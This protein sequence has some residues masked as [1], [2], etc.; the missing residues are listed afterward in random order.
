MSIVERLSSKASKHRPIH[1]EL[2]APA[3]PLA[4]PDLKTTA[5]E[6]GVRY[7]ESLSEFPTSAE[8]VGRIPIA[9]ARTAWPDGTG[10]TRRIICPSDQQCRLLATD[11]YH[12]PLSRPRC[13]ADICTS[14]AVQSAINLAYQERSGQ[15]RQ[16]IEHLDRASVLQELE[17]LTGREDLLDS[18]GRAPVVKLVNLILFEAVQS[19]ASDVHIQPTETTLAVRLR[20]DGVLFDAFELP[21]HLQ[22]EVVGRLKVM[23]RMNIAEKRLAQDGRATAQVGDRAIDL[24]LASLPTSHG[25]RV[26]IRLLDK[27]DSPVPVGRTR[28]GRFNPVALSATDWAGSWTSIGHRPDRFRQNDDVVRGP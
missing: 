26:V 13:N 18:G 25:E 23:G 8:F 27:S 14:P 12:R 24:R 19:G 11:R 16:M 20:L 22:E 15:A 1:L 3:E 10:R 6:L 9:F 21:K 5:S 2:G 28:H 7:L 17:Q 4:R